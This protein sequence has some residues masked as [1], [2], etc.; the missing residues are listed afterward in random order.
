V[1]R[2]PIGGQV[3]DAQ[4]CVPNVSYLGNAEIPP[5]VRLLITGVSFDRPFFKLGGSGCSGEGGTSCLAEGFAFTAVNRGTHAGRCVIPV[6][7]V[8]GKAGDTVHLALAGRVDCPADQN[9]VC[10]PFVQQL[11][12]DPRTI[13][14]TVPQSS[15]SSS[16]STDST[17]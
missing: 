2:L 3:N 8:G 5:G 10:A 16:P 9:A 11:R 12:N 17:S 4:S 13:E 6:R 7:A 14:L 1:P 15:S